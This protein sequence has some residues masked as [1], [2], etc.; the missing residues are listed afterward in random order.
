MMNDFRTWKWMVPGM[1]APVLLVLQLWINDWADTAGVPGARLCGFATMPMMMILL[2]QAWAGF[3]AYYR[4][5]EVD[6]L[7]AKR[8][9]LA[10]T[11]EIRLF[12][13]TKGMHP[14]AVRLLLKHRIAVWRIRETPIDELA[15]WVLDAD[16]R[17]HYRFVEFVLANSNF[18][19]IYPKNRL[20]DK[21]RSFD[22]TGV[23]TDYEQY[24]AFVRLLQN[25]TM[26]TEAYGNQPGLWIEPWKP[27][28]V[29]RNFGVVLEAEEKEENLAA[30]E[31]IE[32][33]TKG[34]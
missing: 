7:S 17:V 2:V 30:V 28:L 24:D 3:Q 8:N 1:A 10:T 6:Q 25:R 14:E 18:Y 12:E 21:A 16:P 13:A 9:A 5:I 22:P 31:I 11:A 29:A 19:N 20:N 23:V 4:Q 33:K 32:D 15:D 34:E 26:L 27:E